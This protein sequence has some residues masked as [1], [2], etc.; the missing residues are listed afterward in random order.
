M[1]E[2]EIVRSFRVEY[3]DEYLEVDDFQTIN[4]ESEEDAR[5]IFED[6]YNGDD[7]YEVTNVEKAYELNKTK[8][9]DLLGDVESI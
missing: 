3:Y 5:S 2:T 7:Q 8:I 9:E 6:Q 4:A 1:T